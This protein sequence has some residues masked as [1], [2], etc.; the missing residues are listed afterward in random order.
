VVTAGTAQTRQDIEASRQQLVSDLEQTGA[1]VKSHVSEVLASA[2]ET[3]QAKVEEAR[4]ETETARKSQILNREN[5]V[6]SG[7]KLTIRYRTYPGLIPT[8]DVYD[9]N[10]VQRVS[11]AS[12]AAIGTTGIYEYDVDF[13]SSWGKGDFTIICSEAEN[14]TLDAMII[15]V[16]KTDLEQVYNQVSAVMGN[17]SGLSSLSNVADGLNSQFGMIEAALSK[18]GKD[19]GKR[20]QDAVGSATAFDSLFSQISGLAKQIK[21]M[22]GDTGV[23]LEKLYQVSSDKKE[24]INYLKNKTQELRA[25]MDLNQKMIQNISEKPVVQRWYEYK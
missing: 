15:S 10:N 16:I 2:Q 24:D 1:T 7:Q 6:R 9:A 13:L 14:G 8:I 23:N 11:K 3:L 5:A 20:V 25:V 17:T 12:M 4:V 21:N 22:G 18:V 19:M